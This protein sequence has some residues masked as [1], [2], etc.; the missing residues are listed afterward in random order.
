MSTRSVAVITG[1]GT[2]IGAATALLL[3]ERGYN[4][5]INYNTSEKSAN[6]VGRKCESL[7]ATVNLIQGDVS[8]DIVCRRVVETAIEN[9]GRIDV[10]I[11]NAG[12]TTFSGR[13]NWGALDKKTFERIY[14]V[15]TLSAFQLIRAAVS[16][17]RHSKGCVINVSSAAG[18]LAR[19]SSIP[20]ILSK[21]ALNALTIYFARALA[22]DVRVNAVCPAL[23]TTDWFKKALGESSY[24]EIEEK[25]IHDCAL[26][27]P[28]SAEDVAQ[29][30]VWL[31]ESG[32]TISGELLQMDSGLRLR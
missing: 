19:G 15:N 24:A 28:N 8:D 2:G 31:A 1:G 14:E 26:Q 30:I 29:A 23:V 3:A 13:D 32:R 27:R 9:F 11:N 12:M 20:Y 7:G 5:V 16:Y 18:T 10:L 21:A 17:L 6:V 4:A 22:P 25:F